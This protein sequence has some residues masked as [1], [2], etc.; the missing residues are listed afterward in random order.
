MNK[1]NFKIALCSVLALI[2][3]YYIGI[4]NVR[5][6]MVANDG[7]IIIQI[8]TF[9]L[10]FGFVFVCVNLGDMIYKHTEITGEQKDE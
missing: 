9:I 3:T 7:S 2:G 5:F 10:L 8:I 1:D 4:S 6:P